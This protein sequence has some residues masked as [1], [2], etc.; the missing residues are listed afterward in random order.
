MPR[1]IKNNTASEPII[2]NL[3]NGLEY[4]SQ[5]ANCLE[6]SFSSTS[7]SLLK[8]ISVPFRTDGHPFKISKYKPKP[9]SIGPN[10]GQIFLACVGKYFTGENAERNIID[11]S[12]YFGRYF[13]CSLISDMTKKA[14]QD[15]NPNVSKGYAE[16]S[17]KIINGVRES[18]VVV[19][20]QHG[21]F[22][23]CLNGVDK[24]IN[25]GELRH[26]YIRRTRKL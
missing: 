14:L 17:Q 22:A 20:L 7:L 5:S 26:Q 9:K 18:A 13:R 25:C 21:L 16:G 1:G 4:L 23:F 11:I 8:L 3:I 6:I 19:S 10:G 12:K 24:K 15:I 2:Y